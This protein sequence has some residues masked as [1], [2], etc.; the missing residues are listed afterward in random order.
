MSLTQAAAQ[1]SFEI[2]IKILI[3]KE[4]DRQSLGRDPAMM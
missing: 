3:H 2:A 4:I 1:N